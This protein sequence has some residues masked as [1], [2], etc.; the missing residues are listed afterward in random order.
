[1]EFPTV[2]RTTNAC[3]RATE[4]DGHPGCDKTGSGALVAAM[5]LRATRR[6]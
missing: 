3:G 6:S 5:S 4:A 2:G 1:M